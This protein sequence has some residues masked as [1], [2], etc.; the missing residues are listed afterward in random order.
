MDFIKYPKTQALDRLLPE[1][2][3]LDSLLS[4]GQ[5]LVIEEK[6]D[7]TQLGLQFDQQA[8]PVL[9]SRGTIITVEP[10]FAW[11][12][13]WVW[14]HYAVLYDCLKQR[15]ILFGEWLWA[16]HTLFY[17]CLPHYWLEFDVYDRE[18][19]IFLSTEAR[20]VLL[21]GL[22]CLH[23]VRVID[24]L[25]STTLSSLWDKVGKSAFI[26]EGA[27]LSL[28]KEI[29]AHTDTSGLMEGLY[30]KIEDPQQVIARY[31]LIR[32]EFVEL[33]VGLGEHWRHRAL[34]KNQLRIKAN[35]E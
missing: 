14:E 5:V 9:Q 22:E 7:G 27:Y 17:D 18:R 23:S 2:A 29:L 19:N 24:T 4:A 11:L 32:P 21:E 34:V 3:S 30:L 13:A 15:Y 31:K 16:K 20:R 8:Q 1:S 28:S 35:N 26:T 10:E 25:Q 33:I 6:M 12:K